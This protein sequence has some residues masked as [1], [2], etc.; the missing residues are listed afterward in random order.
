M[1]RFVFLWTDIALYLI[2]VAGLAYL[3]RVWRSP[4]LRATWRRVAGDTP[5]MCSAVVLA[6]FVAVGLL[7]SIHYQT[8]L[9]PAPNAAPDAPVI[10]APAVTSLLDTLLAPTLLGKPEKTYS[11]PLASYQFTKES[12]VGPDGTVN[13][14]FPRLQHGGRHLQNPAT[15]TWPDARSR[16]LKG[17]GAG[18]AGAL[19]AGVILA[20]LLA[21]RLGL[22]NLLRG[23]TSV[24]WRAMWLTFLLLCLLVGSLGGLATG[25]HVLG[26]DQTGNDVLW[27]AL[28]SVRTG[29]VIGTLTT[30]AMLPPAIAFGIAAGYF[31]G[32]V[33]DA[34][35][36]LYTTLTSIP[37]VLLVAACALMMQVYIENHASYFDTS[38]ARA[39]ARLFILCMILGLTGWSGLCRLLRAETLKLRELEYVQAAR[40]FGVSHWRIMLRHLLPNVMHIVLITAVLE[41]SGLVLYEAVLSYLGIGV[42]PSMNSFGSMINGARFEMSREPMIWWNLLSAFVFLLTLVLAANLFA[43]GVRDAFDPRSRRFRPRL[44]RATGGAQ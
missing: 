18:L 3:W 28:K 42:D 21:R 8:R 10:Y 36:Y 29:L 14:D 19:L 1:P 9:P 20:A 12:M 27:Q 34:I 11:A 13:R 15:D 40:A 33:D 25:Y 7:D 39:D 26:T 17:A 2:A 24:P 6:C 31:R 37:G 23:R 5:A 43:D 38:A 32:R 35:Q 30:L 44:N 16:L 4:N 41:F 22:V